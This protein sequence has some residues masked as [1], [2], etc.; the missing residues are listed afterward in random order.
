[1][2]AAGV[3]EA[4]DVLKESVADLVA[5]YP[6]VSPDQFC[7]EGFEEGLDGSIIVAVASTTHGHFEA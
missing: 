2:F 1:M 7:L 4:V 3:V 5:R 6:S